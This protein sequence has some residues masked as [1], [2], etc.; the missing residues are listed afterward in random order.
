MPWSG[1]QKPVIQAA[2]T[3]WVPG[4]ASAPRERGYTTW[5]QGSRQAQKRVVQ[6]RP[7]QAP[8]SEYP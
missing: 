6:G 4:N 3:H 5:T 8:P 1:V 2:G 7:M